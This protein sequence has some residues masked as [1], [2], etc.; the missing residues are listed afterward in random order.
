M[1]NNPFGEFFAQNDFSKFFEDYKSTPFDLQNF[2]ETQRKNIQALT[3]AQQVSIDN[4]QT[5]AQRQSA[6]LSE[7]IE[8]NAKI[9]QG[10]MS[11]GT[12]EEKISK[13]TD[14]FKTSYERTVKNMNEMAEL[15]NQSN[16]EASGIIDKRI[17]ASLNE[18][19]SS[20]NKSQK[21]AA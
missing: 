12:P 19:K 7:I 8:D 4:L 3:Q 11:E 10:L 5:I 6:I 16:Q 1:S 20:V 15:L 2:M 13:N 17:K 18:F 14:M 21:K 9:A